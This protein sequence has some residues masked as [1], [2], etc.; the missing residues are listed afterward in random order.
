[1]TLFGL[2]QRWQDART[3][4]RRIYAIDLLWRAAEGYS[5]QAGATA[6]AA[7]SYY[8]LLSLFPLLIAVVAILGWTIRDPE[9]QA[10]VV[11]AIVDQLPP[12]ANLRP[13]V[14]A[15]VSGVAD[16]Q[17]GLLGVVGV[18]VALWTATGVITALRRALNRAFDVPGVHSFVHG[19]ALDLLGVIGV[20]GFSMLSVAATTALGI[21]RTAADDRFRGAVTNLAWALVYLLLPL[22]FSFVAFLVV[23]R[24]IP[25]RQVRGAPLWLGALFAALGFELAK[26][27]FGLYVASLGRYTQV[28]GALGGV[29][30]FLVFVFVVSN[31]V[32]F[33]AEVISELLKDQVAKHGRPC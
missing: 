18:A 25:N 4:A 24:L 10:Q 11:D 29:V 30:A 20:M 23:Y 9:L 14:E 6:A 19:K 15:V 8:A 22:A 21:L 31:I 7:M 32:I 1:V 13:Q 17:N 12:D 2:K 33:A 16:T 27:G 26:A 28:Y 5:R 3:T